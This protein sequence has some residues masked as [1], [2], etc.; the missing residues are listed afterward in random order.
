MLNPKE[1]TLSGKLSK[2]Q[3]FLNFFVSRA[4][5]VL[6]FL[7]L[8]CTLL[9]K[10]IHAYRFNFVGEYFNYILSDVS[11][12]LAVDVAMALACFQWRRVWLIRICIVIAAV[13]CTWSFFNAGWLI[14]TGT[15]ILPRVLLSVFLSPVDSFRMIGANLLSMPVTAFLL[16]TPGFFAISFLVYVLAKSRP[17]SYKQEFFIIR[18]IILASLSLITATIRPSFIRRGSTQPAQVGLRYNAHISA[19][20]SLFIRDG[21]KPL[22]SERQVPTFEQV[23]ININPTDAHKTK[24]NVVIIVLEGVQ[25]GCTSFSRDAN[26]ITPYMTEV[27]RQG[28]HFSSTHSI[29]THTTKAIFSLLTGRYPSA[30]QDIAEAVPV[31]KPYASIA[32][33]LSN[34]LG[35]RTAF[36][37]SAK[38][39][40]EGRASLVHNLGFEKFWSREQLDDPSSFLGYLGSDEFKMLEPIKQWITQS[41]EPFLLTILTSVTHD[42]YE[43]PKQYDTTEKEEKEI[44]DLYKQTIAYTD[45]FIAALD[46]EISRLNL[47]ENTIFCVIGD[48][49]EAFGE[50]GLLGHERIGYQEAVHVPFFMRAPSLIKPSTEIKSTVSSVDLTPTLL[51]LLGFKTEEA[52]F[53]GINVLGHIPADR[54]V[55][56]TSWMQESPAGYIQADRKYIYDT[57]QKSTYTYD[58]KTDPGESIRIDLSPEQANKISENIINWR[59]NTVFRIDQQQNGTQTVFG[60]WFCRWADRNTVIKMKKETPEEPG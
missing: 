29:L 39:D 4:F 8:T 38:G 11:F 60:E 31:E 1:E 12:L 7:A 20:A 14:R 46:A 13:I 16:L 18:I 15:Q 36:F 37:Q 2:E 19:I 54:K 35:Y 55:Y 26:N 17:P 52:K 34:K 48:H 3:L 41:P 27:A 6:I 45:S 51:S 50:H 33:I 53:D 5:E 10:L 47:Y 57:M 25:Y 58:L 21:S 9:V 32:T 23:K 43:V 56:F 44:V 28:V 40:F 24:R 30:S 42:P 22:V 49:G 59:D